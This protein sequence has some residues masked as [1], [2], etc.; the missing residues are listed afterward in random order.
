MVPAECAWMSTVH[1][2]LIWL[3]RIQTLRGCGYFHGG[4]V[5]HIKHRHQHEQHR[6]SDQVNKYNQNT[7]YFQS[8]HPADESRHSMI[9]RQPPRRSACR[10]DRFHLLLQTSYPLPPCRSAPS[11]FARGQRHISYAQESENLAQTQARLWTK[12]LTQ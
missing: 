6:P 5:P 7:H 4:T 1:L 9:S 11:G 12:C 2:T 10:S 3:S 8:S